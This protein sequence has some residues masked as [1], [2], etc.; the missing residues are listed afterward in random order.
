MTVKTCYNGIGDYEK[1]SAC[2]HGD[3]KIKRFL[4]LFLKDD[5]FEKLEKAL[6]EDD[7]ETAFIA[8]HTL[9]GV[10][11]NLALDPLYEVDVVVTEA[12]RAKNLKAAK[13]HFPRVK[14]EYEKAYQRI[15]QL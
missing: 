12:L 11:Q 4:G 2:F 15:S 10:C 8:A 1:M 14:E 7:V 3:D 13:E 9:K 5:N 6:E